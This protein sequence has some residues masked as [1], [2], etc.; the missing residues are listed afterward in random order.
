MGRAYR[1]WML[2]C[3]SMFLLVC[4]LPIP[5]RAT[6]D[7]PPSKPLPPSN[8]THQVIDTSKH[9]ATEK[10]DEL[11]VKVLLERPYVMRSQ[12][13]PTHFE[14]M[15]IDVLKNLTARLN[16]PFVILPQT[17]DTY[18]YE[19]SQENWTGLI[20]SVSRKEAHL[21]V[22]PLTIVSK[23]SSVVD[24]TQPIM[25]SGLRILYKPSNPWT[26]SESFSILLTPF[27]AGMWVVLLLLFLAVS[28]AFYL[29]G[30]FSPYEDHAF[31]GK[32]AT[33][34]G[35][36]LTNSFLYVFSSLTFQG[37]TA[38]P[39]SMSGR[40]LAG[41]WWVFVLLVVA[42]YTAC[43][44]SIFLAFKPSITTLPF[45][46][47]DELSQQ[48][49][50]A[51]GT[52]R[53]GSAQRYLNTSTRP[54]QRRLWGT[55][56]ANTDAVMVNSITEGVHKVRALPGRYAFI[57]EGPMAEYQSEQ[58]PCDLVTVGEELN[59]HNWGFACQKG[60]DVCSRL[61]H[62]ILQMKEEDFI[63][64]LK[65]KWLHQGCNRDNTGEY[66]FQGLSYLDTFGTTPKYYASRSVT[67]RRF[68]IGFLC[69]V[70]GMT[71]SACLLVA[72]IFLA[73]RRGSPVPQRL[74]RGGRED[75]ERI[76]REFRDDDN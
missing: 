19:H 42:A 31:V 2:P 29:I 41:F 30:R 11:K 76:D 43:L 45:A 53:E 35:L 34:E 65:K 13:D 32:A 36:T 58:A 75:Q 16:L 52:V 17:D 63:F 8:G 7:S 26:D 5:T 57:M 48:S 55:M 20:G 1:G 70:I 54:L 25:S 10:V 37:Y 62:A 3:V 51:Y 44:C 33:Y 59:E 40:V 56:H 4:V 9:E 69:I 23:R 64:E 39:R 71:I 47:F 66:I 61:N 73:K 24:F 21:A 50:V 22:A 6:Q 12:Q 14:G 28:V 49:H 74:P 60:T 38:A 72:E 18:G 46:T 15:F 68:G 67:L 27:T